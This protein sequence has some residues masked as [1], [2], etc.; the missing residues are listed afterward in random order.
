VTREEPESQLGQRLVTLKCFGPGRTFVQQHI[1]VLLA[2]HGATANEQVQLSMRDDVP[3]SL[4]G[5]FYA[6]APQPFRKLCAGQAPVSFKS[7]GKHNFAAADHFPAQLKS[8]F[9]V[10]QESTDSRRGHPL[11][12]ADIGRPDKV[13]RR[14]QDMSAQES[15][16]VI[17][18]NHIRFSAALDALTYRPLRAG[19]VL[20]LYRAKPPHGGFRRLQAGTSYAL[21]Q[22]PPIDDAQVIH[23][24]GVTT[25][26]SA[27]TGTVRQK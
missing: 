14:A 25:S 17:R 20:G 6:S 15:A 3:E 26:R 9:I 23:N 22:E 11:H 19:E 16:T 7:V 5:R 21:V 18:L 10:G 2:A 24:D 1:C 13:P 27:T 8:V 4:S 12:P